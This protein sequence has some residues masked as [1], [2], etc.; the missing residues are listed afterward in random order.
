[1]FNPEGVN[2]YQDIKNA[3]VTMVT[4][5]GYNTVE[6]AKSAGI[7]ESNIMT[8]PGPTEILAAVRAGRADAGGVTYFTAQNLAKQSDLKALEKKID[9]LTKSLAAVEKKLNS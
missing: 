8:V 6:D 7:S 2:N 4:G 1:M 9:K 5:A 3:G